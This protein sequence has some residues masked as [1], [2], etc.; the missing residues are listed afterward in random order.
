M[1]LNHFN[2]NITPPPKKNS[3][4]LVDGGFNNISVLLVEEAG[5]NPTPTPP[6]PILVVWLMPVFSAT[7]NN[8]SVITCR[9]VL[10]VEE[11]G[12]NHWPVASHWQTLSHNLVP[13]T[14]HHE[15]GSNSWS[16]LWWWKALNVQVVVNPTT[17]RSQQ[18][19]IVPYH[20][21]FWWIPS[22]YYFI[23]FFPK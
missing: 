10:L 5:D 21:M 17:M 9:S 14:P 1:W 20:Q 19:P 16:Q 22:D 3:S 8:I 23:Y 13:S 11:A 18:I 15:L 6:P 4:C 2:W 7:F 12:E